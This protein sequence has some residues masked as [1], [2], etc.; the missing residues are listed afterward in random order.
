M[1]KKSLDDP[2]PGPTKVY[3][4]NLSEDVWSFIGSMSPADRLHEIAENAFLSD[5]DILTCSSWSHGIL[6]VPQTID[7]NFAQYCQKV[8]GFS[9]LQILVP[10]HH[11]GELCLDVLSDK[12]CYQTL[13]TIG[14][15]TPLELTSY[16][17]SPQFYELV[18]R[19]IAAGV[20]VSLPE[21]PAPSASWTPNFF[22]SKSGFRQLISQLSHHKPFPHMSHGYISFGI[23]ET[24]KIASHMYQK[25][26]GVVIKTT[27]GHSGAGVMII[28][29]GSMP[30]DPP[31]LIAG[32]TQKLQA[33]KYWS[34]FPTIIEKFVDIDSTVG[35]GNPNVEL[36]VDAAGMVLP[37]YF[38]G[39][40]VTAAGVFKGVEIHRSA[41]SKKLVKQ[42]E[43]IGQLVGQ[44]YARAG[45]VGYFDIDGVVSK[46][47][48]LF[49]AES[50]VR[51]TG[52]TH[53]YHAIKTVIGDGF[54]DEVF[55]VSNNVYSLPNSPASPIASFA[56]LRDKLRPV[57]FNH[58]TKSGVIL[59]SANLLAQQKIAYLVIGPTKKATLKIEAEMEKLLH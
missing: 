10:A 26:G 41:L 7:P 33:E 49:L 17:A 8:F 20:Q 5:R 51:K 37:L 13:L 4:S 25:Y 2:G 42:L 18:S 53:V 35:G 32:I 43:A 47:G 9:D 54:L 50:N 16:S 30:T 1:S 27:K 48:E 36:M 57:L 59:A 24:A 15:T 19:L 21:S 38:C 23:R 28:P 31:A 56:E 11:T 52:G 34:L 40:R 45:Y 46:S 12:N 3:L 6:I 14:K 29:P 58:T 39:M 55:V 22:G 44:A